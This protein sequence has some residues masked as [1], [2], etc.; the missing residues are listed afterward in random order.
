MDFDDEEAEKQK[1]AEQ[2]RL[3]EEAEAAAARTRQQQ[4]DDYN[5][6]AQAQAEA[7]E[8]ATPPPEPEKPKDDEYGR[9]LIV[10]GQGGVT[11]NG[12]DDPGPVSP[13]QSS[14]AQPSPA[15]PG[16]SGGEVLRQYFQACQDNDA[17]AATKLADENHF[18]PAALRHG[19]NM[20]V[21]TH[22]NYEG[23]GGLLSKCG[24]AGASGV[25]AGFMNDLLDRTTDKERAVGFLQG[26][27]AQ[28]NDE[29]MMKIQSTNPADAVK[30]IKAGQFDA[31]ENGSRC[32]RRA[33]GKRASSTR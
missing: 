6:T 14:P 8:P 7:T 20:L 18:T 15:L 33:T 4:Q 26:M 3:Q 5:R 19:I 27:G 1:K 24:I 29:H 9:R 23:A 32:M 12:I 25:D 2:K 10:Q 30:I 13:V 16:K 11:M 22:Q 17:T 21:I 28:F 31:T